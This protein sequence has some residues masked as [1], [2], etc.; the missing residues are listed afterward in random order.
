M[1]RA[2][3]RSFFANILFEPKKKAFNNNNIRKRLVKALLCAPLKKGEYEL[4]PTLIK[5]K[6]Y[7]E[8]LL[9][10]VWFGRDPKYSVQ[11]FDLLRGGY[12]VPRS[13]NGSHLSINAQLRKIRVCNKKVQHLWRAPHYEN[14]GG[15]LGQLPR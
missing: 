11:G 10:C 12:K 15:T 4:F 6:Y 7:C 3:E 5:F 1:N 14:I 9:G 13:F 8:F 2:Q